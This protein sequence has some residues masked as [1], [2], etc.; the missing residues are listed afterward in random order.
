[1]QLS[2]L[3]PPSSPAAPSR[4]QDWT[5]V[6]NPNSGIALSPSFEYDP[7]TGLISM[8]NIGPNGLVDSGDNT[9]LLG[10]DIGMISFQVTTTLPAGRCYREF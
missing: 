9:T 2:L 10:D 3:S 1:M 8:S 6:Q 5:D 7:D 4:A